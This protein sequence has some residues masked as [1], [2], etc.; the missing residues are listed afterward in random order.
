MQRTLIV[1]ASGYLGQRL[2]TAQFGKHVVG[3]YYQNFKLGLEYL[4]VCKSGAIVDFIKNYKPELVLFAAGMTNVDRCKK[5]PELA[6]LVNEAAAK[7]IANTSK[8]KMIY[9]STDYVFDGE[10]GNYSEEDQPNPINVY[11]ES[12]L[13]GEKAVLSANP[14]N[15]VI[16]V[17]GLYDSSGS[18]DVR[19]DSNIDESTTIFADENRFS[20]PVHLD[21]VVMATKILIQKNESGIFHVAGDTALSRYEFQKLLVYNSPIQR[22]VVSTSYSQKEKIAPRPLNTSLSM[23]KLLKHGWRSRSVF[24]TFQI[25]V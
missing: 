17:S 7:I 14:N 19:L 8:A 6:F 16:R 1:G 15:L 9:Y 21:D 20:N 3:T 12:K 4:D 5:E 13:R 23:D 22:K 25:V 2:M 10:K 24:E 11:G 18:K